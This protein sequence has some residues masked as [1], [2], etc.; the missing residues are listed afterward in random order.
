MRGPGGVTD[1]LEFSNWARVAMAIDA[2]KRR[3]TDLWY[4]RDS[5]W[6]ENIIE[7]DG[8]DGQL[9]GDFEAAC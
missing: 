8:V 9:E 2:V 1:S 3:I 5:E 4:W 6:E 7:D